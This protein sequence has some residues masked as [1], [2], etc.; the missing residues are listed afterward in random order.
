MTVDR[1]ITDPHFDEPFLSWYDGFFESV[2]LA[3]HPFY[4]V[5]GIDPASAPRA[6]LVYDRNELP[7]KLTLEYLDQLSREAEKLHTIDLPTLQKLEKE[8]GEHVSWHSV[9][10]GCGF[11]T[12]ADINLALK[13]TIMALN[14]NFKNDNYAQRLQGY[15]CLQQIF[16]PG[17]SSMQPIMEKPMLK[18]LQRLRPDQVILSDEF[19]ENC[20]EWNFSNSNLFETW[21]RV[22]ANG[23][24]LNKIYTKENSILMIVP[25]DDFYTAI[26]GDHDL[27]FAA[28]VEDLFEGFWCDETTRP[29]WWHHT[30]FV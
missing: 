27:L 24:S 28:G 25:Y 6:T 19:N 17:D 20:V 5:Q 22:E 11:E 4:K 13:T 15:C 21:S 1:R 26:C 14:K 2:Y 23:L 12:L 16:L 29:Q 7:E 30:R 8:I 9:K 18:L 3:L 10:T